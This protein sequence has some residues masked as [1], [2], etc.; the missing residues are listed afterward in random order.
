MLTMAGS[1]TADTP[2][3]PP[4]SIPEPVKNAPLWLAMFESMIGA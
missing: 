4:P 3:G 1:G 2:E